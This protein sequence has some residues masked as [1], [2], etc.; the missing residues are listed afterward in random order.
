[1]ELITEYGHMCRSCGPS[2]KPAFFLRMFVAPLLFKQPSK[3]KGR[4]DVRLCYDK[5]ATMT[6][7]K[8]WHLCTPTGTYVHLQ[9]YYDQVATSD[10]GA[11]VWPPRLFIVRV[12]YDVLTSFDI[13]SF[14]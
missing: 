8:R 2:L 9:K 4:T 5:Q 13:V 3:R 6:A 10:L 11:E 1:M 12:L 7:T 14:G